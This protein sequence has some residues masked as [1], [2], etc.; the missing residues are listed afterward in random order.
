MQKVVGSPPITRS[1]FFFATP[2]K[3]HNGLS[4]PLR[5]DICCLSRIYFP[6]PIYDGSI[7]GMNHIVLMIAVVI[8]QSVRA[9]KDYQ[10]EPG[11]AGRTVTAAV[12]E[13]AL[14]KLNPEIELSAHSVL[15]RFSRTAE[16]STS[17]C[18]G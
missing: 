10:D 16:S 13:T 2:Q 5:L 14:S 18:A 3:N 1:I 17:V 8:G 9:A 6:K 4:L 15:K 11:K 7:T 12:A